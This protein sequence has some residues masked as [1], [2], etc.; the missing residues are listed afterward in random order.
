MLEF[1]AVFCPWL[2]FEVFEIGGIEAN[3]GEDVCDALFGQRV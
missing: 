2:V 1:L 3:E